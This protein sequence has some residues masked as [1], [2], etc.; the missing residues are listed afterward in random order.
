MV[1]IVSAL[2]LHVAAQAQRTESETASPALVI[3]GRVAAE[4]GDPIARARVAAT[5]AV[6]GAPV[7]LTDANGRF[8]FTAASPKVTLTIARTGYATTEITASVGTPVDTRLARGAAVEGRV[9]D[10]TGEP[11]ANVSVIVLS[12][13]V[14]GRGPRYGAALTDDR[15]EYRIGGLPSG[16]FNVMAMSFGDNEAQTVALRP[17]DVQSGIDFV[18]HGSPLANGLVMIVPPRDDGSVAPVGTGT[19]RGTV[20]TTDGHSIPHADVQLIPPPRTIAPKRASSDGNGR[21]AFDN[22]PAGT[23]TVIATKSGYTSPRTP[24][25]RVTVEDDRPVDVSLQFDPIGA[26][27]GEVWDEDGDPVAGVT[28]QALEI[29][30]NRGSRRLVPASDT[31]VT[32]DLGRYRL[33]G[34]TPGQYVVMAAPGGAPG[35]V[36]TGVDMPG[37]GRSFFPGTTTPS[38]AQFVSVSSGGTVENINLS[39]MRQPTAR[40]TGRLFDS[41]GQPTMGGSLLLIPSVRSGAAVMVPMGARVSRDG[42]FEF[43]GVP[44]GRYIV[45]ADRGRHTAAW[46]GEYGSIP[47]VVADRDVTGLVLQ[48]KPGSTI[49]GRILLDSASGQELSSA[50]G[51]TIQ[52]LPVDFDAAPRQVATADI[53]ED[54]AFI[55]QGVTGTRR[56]EVTRAPAGWM[57]EAVRAGD[58]DITDQAV[59]FGTPAQSRNDIEIVLTDRLSGVAGTVA[60][61]RGSGVAGVQVIVFPIDDALRYAGSRYFATAHTSDTGAFNMSGVPPGSYYV[62]LIS[63]SRD[64]DPDSWQDPQMLES[65]ARAAQSIVVRDGETTTI[66]LHQGGQ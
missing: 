15:G 7:T 39:L 6:A 44:P 65:F 58:A 35:L 46:E 19:V 13:A 55:M 25:R 42:I 12:R 37:Y 61:D 2:S 53:R 4:N 32:D 59:E 45:Q 11:A 10:D 28:V 63:R 22:L 54:G 56:V 30:Y 16:T 26:I 47:V 17:G 36:G 1:T 60:N 21:F 14:S 31:R 27:A 41:T 3:S 49:V 62:A 5:P 18:V 50:S 57:L 9:T 23:Y 33:F 29:R 24:T 43:A 64:K 66:N 51:I 40:I 8:S 48:M 34:L 52:P 20:M 38:D